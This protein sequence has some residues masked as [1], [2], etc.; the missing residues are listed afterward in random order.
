MLNTANQY[1]K[2]QRLMNTKVVST[3]GITQGD[4]DL[5]AKDPAVKSYQTGYSQDVNLIKENR[6]VRFFAYDEKNKQGLNQYRVVSGKLPTE[7]GEIALD[8]KAYLEG[9]FKLGD[10]YIV[11]SDE[12]GEKPFKQKK[13]KIVGFVNSPMY[14]ENATRGNTNVGKG[15]IDYFAV[16]PT[17][18]FSLETYT[19]VYITYKDLV[20][21]DTYTDRY[22]KKMH[23]NEKRLKKTFR[24][25]PTD[26]LNEIKKE[27]EKPLNEAK[28]KLQDGESKLNEGV[29]EL[30]NGQKELA[31]GQAKYAEA[32]AKYTQEIQAAETKLTNS[33]AELDAGQQQLATQ[34]NQLIQGEAALNE[35][36]QKIATAEQEFKNKGIDP[37]SNVSQWQEQK[38]GLIVLEQHGS[39]LSADMQQTLTQVPEGQPIPMDKIQT[40]QGIISA[41][42]MTALQG[43]INEL[44]SNPLNHEAARQMIGQLDSIVLGYQTQITAMTGMIEA[45]ASFQAGRDQYLAQ[46]KTLEEGKVQLAAAQEQLAQGQSQLESGR[47]QLAEA[48]ASGQNQL[49]EA[50][51]KLA[52]A[53]DK[54]T[55]GQKKLEVE[56]QKLADGKAELAKE[57]KKLNEIKKPEY[58]YFSRK[59]NPG[60]A[61]YRE[62][63]KRISSIATVFP[64]FFLMIA[65]LVSLTTMTRMVDEK[66]TELG[67]LKALGYK[68]WEIAQKYV[69][70]A[71]LASLIGSGLGIVIGYNVFPTV[72]Y[73]AYGSLYNLPEIIL[74]YYPSYMIQSIIV[75]LLCTVISALV[76][77]R[78]DLISS[79]SV[80][81]RPRAPK[82][83]QRIFLERLTFIWKKMNFNQKVTARN[84]FRYK[85]RMLM[86]I[87][88]IAGC[89]AMIITGFGLKDSISDIVTIQF[90]KLWHYQAVVTYNEKATTE[91]TANYQKE[92]AK[93]EG[94]KMAMPV[95]QKSMS[96]L[97]DGV[98]TQ[99]L[100]INV[101]EQPADISKFVLFHDR[102]TKEQFE[103]S[104][105]GAIINEKLANLYQ[106]KAGDTL[107]IKDSNNQTYQVKIAHVVEN[108]IMHF[109]YMTPAYYQ[110]VFNEE[111]VFNSELLLFN[112]PPKNEAKVSEKLMAT[113]KAVN[114]SF[115]TQTSSAL[116]DT[117]GSLTIVVWVLITS[118]AILAFIVL[119]NLTNINISER[120]RELSTIKVLG[121]YDK[122][123]TA[124]VYR[125]NNILTVIGILVGCVGG[126]LLHG[127]VLQTAEVDMLMFSP[128]IHWQSYVYS[129]ILTFFFSMV[130]MGLMHRKLRKVDMIE[131]LKSTE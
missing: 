71:A 62:N 64:V 32:Q 119:Y 16:V 8:N 93:I 90:N 112:P 35:A 123:V 59:D 57:E 55:E 130:V 1:F 74:T 122:E 31:D 41:T 26:R 18:D 117:M 43:Q 113:K 22:D 56:K 24:N 37:N 40:W 38:A 13:Y 69:I 47:Q 125:E 53:A 114:V 102:R 81:M 17:K 120:I 30:A 4:L 106:V 80:L 108:Y 124:Y 73:N 75:A 44:M 128:T 7:S 86:T 34:T 92:L 126:K 11:A 101:P 110:K 66:R 36:A 33:Q 76:V 111:P 49:A 70:Y 45:V 79:P 89:M 19:E 60:F 107:T 46:R 129:A 96:A 10:E 115:M 39:Q 94:F 15:S 48:K 88:G 84:L 100:T 121:F 6:V 52:D 127:F 68:N 28:A 42:G 65:A 72:I 54:L 20:N 23:A 118:A 105:N 98:T 85:Q 14:I 82:A 99:E 61:E 131:A 25:R 21:E 91:E 5:L 27:A 51:Q 83:G 116:D 12:A 50:Q 109:A 58:F 87:L 103:L 9:D 78:L 67:T 29:A 97:K 104:D 63:A 2:D 3:L 95:A 77:L